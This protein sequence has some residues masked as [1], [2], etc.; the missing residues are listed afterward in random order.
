MKHGKGKWMQ[1]GSNINCNQY[2]GDFVMDKKHGTG[3]F[4]W[5][6]GNWYKG[7]YSDNLRHG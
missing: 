4:K 2:E 7:E 5:E 1:D 3:I 6:S